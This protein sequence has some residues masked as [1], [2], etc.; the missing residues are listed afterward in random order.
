MKNMEKK[1][2]TLLTNTNRMKLHRNQINLGF[3]LSQMMVL[4][5][6]A[7][8]WTLFVEFVWK[9]YKTNLSFTNILL[10]I[11]HT[12]A[13]S[14][15]TCLHSTDRLWSIELDRLVPAE[16][17]MQHITFFGVHHSLCSVMCETF[18]FYEKSIKIP[19]KIQMN[20]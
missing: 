12:V 1:Y 10:V 17:A 16:A 18:F 9:H 13:S 2:Q 6:L 14:L 7:V 19:C 5:M 8:S 11:K 15:T 20:T 3:K 4:T